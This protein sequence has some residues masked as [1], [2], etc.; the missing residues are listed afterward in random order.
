MSTLYISQNKMFF[1][2]MATQLV[3]AAIVVGS[4]FGVIHVQEN[5]NKKH[6]ETNAVLQ[7]IQNEDL[8]FAKFFALNGVQR[9]QTS[10]N[11]LEACKSVVK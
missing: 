3:I 2:L 5:Q 7:S 6:N 9:A 1:V 10:I 4:L 11:Q 8:C